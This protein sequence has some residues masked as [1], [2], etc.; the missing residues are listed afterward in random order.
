MRFAMVTLMTT[1]LA[2]T[3]A[4]GGAGWRQRRRRCGRQGSWFQRTTVYDFDDDNSTASCCPPKCQHR[5]SRP[6]QAR[7]LDHHRPHFIP[8]LIKMAQDV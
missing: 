4:W 7:Q 6:D 2:S 8:E 3:N 5:L 1:L